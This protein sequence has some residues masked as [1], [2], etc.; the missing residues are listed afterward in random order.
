ETQVI[1]CYSRAKEYRHLWVAEML[2]VGAWLNLVYAVQHPLR[3]FTEWFTRVCKPHFTYETGRVWRR[4]AAHVEREGDSA[5]QIICS[6]AVTDALTAL[7]SASTA[8]AASEPDQ[9]QGEPSATE[10]TTSETT[11]TPTRTRA[12]QDNDDEIIAQVIALARHAQ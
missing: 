5:L 6:H 11:T 1:A 12:D 10:T 9:T 4:L 3:R 2:K 8:E 7:K